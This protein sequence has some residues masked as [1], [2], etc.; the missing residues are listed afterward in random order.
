MTRLDL[1]DPDLLLCDLMDG[2][3]ETIPVFLRHRM[4][5]IGCIVGAFHTV[6]DACAE[7]RVDETDFR[8]ELRRAV[9]AARPR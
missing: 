9:R 3:P 8:A 6:T 2:W 1:H 5:C 7:Y 4:L